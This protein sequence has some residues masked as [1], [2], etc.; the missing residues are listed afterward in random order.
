MTSHAPNLPKIIFFVCAPF[1]LVCA[2]K[3]LVWAASV[4]LDRL[5]KYYLVIILRSCSKFT[6]NNLLC[7]CSI[8]AS[9]VPQKKLFVASFFLDIKIIFNDH[10][11]VTQPPTCSKFPLIVSFVCASFVLVIFSFLLLTFLK[12]FS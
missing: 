5:S 8:C 12:I 3:K 1:V 10:S 2:V 9:F 6:P 4:F 11:E 7:L